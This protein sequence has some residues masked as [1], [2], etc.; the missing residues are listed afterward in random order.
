MM[1]HEFAPWQTIHQ[2][3]M[4]WIAA[5]C[6][7]AM[8]SDLRAIVRLALERSEQPTAAIYDGRTVQSTPESGDRA[9]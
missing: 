8:A 4:R 2:Q 1:P 9:G 6:F 7:E 3:T 5:G